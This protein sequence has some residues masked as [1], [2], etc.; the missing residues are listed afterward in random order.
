MHE[1]WRVVSDTRTNLFACCTDLQWQAPYAMVTD[2]LLW[3][4]DDDCLSFS[5]HHFHENAASARAR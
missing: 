4:P 5:V 3:T 1:A 2:E